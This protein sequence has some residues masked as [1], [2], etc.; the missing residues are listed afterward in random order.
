M[1]EHAIG[2]KTFKMGDVAEDGSMG[3]DLTALPDTVRG[4]VKF[5]ASEPSQTKYWVNNKPRPVEA[6]N[7]AEVTEQIVFEFYDAT[8][9]VI[10]GFFGGTSTAEVADT[11]GAKYS[12]ASAIPQIK[13]SFEAVTKNGVTLSITRGLLAPSIEWDLNDNG[14]FKG[15]VTVLVLQP[16]NDDADAWSYELP[17]S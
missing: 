4:T 17:L 5:T 15:K 16:E 12:A 10:A 1:S 6:L 3:T 2:L 8:P 14:I 9:D 7:E 11:S 13:Q